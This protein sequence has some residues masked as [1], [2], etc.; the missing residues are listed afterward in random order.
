MGV[1]TWRATRGKNCTRRGNLGGR[2]ARK[3]DLGGFVLKEGIRE[4]DLC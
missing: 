1:G 4:D 2:G 3:D